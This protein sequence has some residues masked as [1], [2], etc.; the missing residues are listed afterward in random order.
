MARVRKK[1][2]GASSHRGVKSNDGLSQLKRLRQAW[3]RCRSWAAGL[4][5][6]RQCMQT[7]IKL[8]CC[9]DRMIVCACLSGGT[10]RTPHSARLSLCPMPHTTVCSHDAVLV[11]KNPKCRAPLHRELISPDPEAET[12]RRR[13]DKNRRGDEE[14]Q[15]AKNPKHKKQCA[16]QERGAATRWNESAS[17]GADGVA[18]ATARQVDNGRG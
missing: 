4:R 13:G 14:D 9:K 8:D 12:V 16:G 1:L 15:E 11:Q 5:Q 10:K 3:A 17:R 2:S 7:R 18:T 6:D